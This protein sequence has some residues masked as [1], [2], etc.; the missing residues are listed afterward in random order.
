MHDD[1]LPVPHMRSEPGRR[2]R[3]A[4]TPCRRPRHLRPAA[5]DPACGQPRPRGGGAV[6]SPPPPCIMGP[7]PHGS[8]RR[9]SHRPLRQALLPS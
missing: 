1:S 4:P 6:A 7:L 2:S 9:R 8:G 5:A 3:R